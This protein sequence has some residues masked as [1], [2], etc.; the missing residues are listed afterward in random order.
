MPPKHK[1][2]M[3]G[4]SDLMRRK[5]ELWYLRRLKVVAE[6]MKADVVPQ[7]QKLIAALPKSDDE[8][9]HG[10]RMNVQQG[11]AT[12]LR[13][14][15]EHYTAPLDPK[16]TSR[17]AA[18]M[19]LQSTDAW[20][21]KQMK[22]A[23]VPITPAHLPLPRITMDATA[24]KLSLQQQRILTRARQR[25]GITVGAV[26]PLSTLATIHG[27]PEIQAAFDTA[28]TTNVALIKSLP[29]QY[30]DRLEEILFDQVR[31]AEHWETLV[32]RMNDG[33]DQANNLADYR[34]KLIAR[35]QTA[36]MS[37]AFNEARCRSVGIAQYTWQTAGDERVRESHAEN[38]GQLFS[39]DEG[40]PIDDDG[41]L[42]NPGD[43]VNCRCVALPYVEE[44][45]EEDAEEAA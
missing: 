30:F 2:L 21:A 12:I 20:F 19:N 34:V 36:K 3:T 44:G 14:A 10:E 8:V 24:K 22:A 18:A 11:V 23:M 32:D 17:F 35:D 4:K 5:N 40:A 41:T 39:F 42:G 29:T 1:Q 28:V 9:S 25:A 16:R 26:R 38:D 31:S 27:Q 15:R 45:E 6:D 43:A 33:I 13:E 37:A 7:L